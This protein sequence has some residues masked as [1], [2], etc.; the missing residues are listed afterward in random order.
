MC[1]SNKFCLS[2]KLRG[3]KDTNWEGGTRAVGFIWS[4]L[5]ETSH[6]VS[7]HLMHVSDWLPTLLKVAGYDMNSLPHDHLDGFDMWDVLSMN[8]DVSPRTEVLYNIDPVDKTAAIRVQNMKL[9]L[10]FQVVSDWFSQPQIL[11]P[12]DL[13]LTDDQKFSLMMSDL[14]FLISEALGREFHTGTPIVVDCGQRTANATTNC[15]PGITPCLFDLDVDPCEYNNLAD[16]MPET[17]TKLL[18]RLAA[19]NATAVSCRKKPD[20]LRGLPFYNCGTFG[21]W[22]DLNNEE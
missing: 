2:L 15:N 19:Y 12:T 3:E 13:S 21:P 17:V 9:I 1:V 8:E 11:P 22:I 14:P 7:N 4:P 16:L 6:Y 5:L 10:G 18:Q 20:D